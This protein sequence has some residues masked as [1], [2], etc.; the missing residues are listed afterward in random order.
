MHEPQPGWSAAA[1]E[2][3]LSRAA[4]A[5]LWLA[6]L[7]GPLVFLLVVLSPFAGVG[8]DD[9]TGGP[10]HFVGIALIV[11]ICLTLLLGLLGPPQWRQPEF[12]ML[13][14]FWLLLAG[15]PS[16]LLTPNTSRLWQAVPALLLAAFIPIVVYVRRRRDPV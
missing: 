9:I 13:A 1:S 14:L 10:I 11:S 12:I 8:A 5:A 6:W 15:V 4:R 7:L 3:R 2:S 16:K